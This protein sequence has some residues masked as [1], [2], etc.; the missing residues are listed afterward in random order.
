M[1]F[2]GASIVVAVFFV[3]VGPAVPENSSP[4]SRSS[5]L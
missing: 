5:T 3:T 4:A 2:W 1:A